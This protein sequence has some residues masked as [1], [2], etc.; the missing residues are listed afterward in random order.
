M[1]RAAT[2][3]PA[4]KAKHRPTDRKRLHFSQS[5]GPDEALRCN[6][7]RGVVLEQVI[8]PER[9]LMG[10]A[11]RRRDRADVAAR[12]EARSDAVRVRKQRLR[13][14]AHG[15]IGERRD[16][17]ERI[18]DAGGEP[19]RVVGDAIGSRSLRDRRRPPAEVV[20]HR[21]CGQS[22]GRHLRHA[23][24]GI[25]RG[26]GA[27]ARRRR[28]GDRARAAV[29]SALIATAVHRR[30]FR[31]RRHAQRVVGVRQ[32]HGPAVARGARDAGGSCAVD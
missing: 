4:I 29:V 19:L 30:G 16:V 6:L 7:R 31:Q 18:G 27:A 1:I 12:I 9:E 17:V 15:V 32:G 20:L 14:A 24:E 26:H 23:T 3:A 13:R 11:P 2:T 28:G 8:R 21:H 22:R 10:R 5:R 25:Q